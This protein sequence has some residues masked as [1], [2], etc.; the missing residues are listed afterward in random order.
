MGGPTEAAKEEMMG[1][2]VSIDR[3]KFLGEFI[4]RRKAPTIIGYGFLLG[5]LATIVVPQVVYCTIG[6]P[7]SPWVFVVSAQAGVIVG[8]VKYIRPPATVAPLVDTRT[9]HISQGD[10]SK[11]RKLS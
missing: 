7:I 3:G 8:L 11:D 5:V 9:A 10:R 6:G 1:K 4:S 2:V